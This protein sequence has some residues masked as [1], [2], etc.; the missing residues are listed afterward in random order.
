[1]AF[2]PFEI[3]QYKTG[4]SK[5]IVLEKL[6]SIVER[7]DILKSLTGKYSKRFIGRINGNNIKIVNNTRKYRNSFSAIAF[8]KIF[9]DDNDDTIIDVFMRM[10]IFV[11]IFMIIWL[12][13]CIFALF[14][15]LFLMPFDYEIEIIISCL[16][17]I[18]LFIIGYSFMTGLFKMESRKIKENLEELFKVIIIY[19]L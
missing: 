18:I 12:G 17:I 4:F 15:V 2:I 1:M 8:I 9:E 6:N 7:E 10:N 14:I 19:E 13:G 16:P 11:I 3:I 5:N